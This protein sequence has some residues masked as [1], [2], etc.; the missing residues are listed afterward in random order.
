MN[1]FYN[2]F[3]STP[4]Q[5]KANAI[6]A[7][8][9]EE[10]FNFIF[11]YETGETHF[12]ANATNFCIENARDIK[13]Y[14]CSKLKGNNIKKD[15]Y[16]AI[17]LFYRNNQRVIYKL[18]NYFST[19]GN[20]ITLDV[21][22]CAWGAKKENVI[23]AVPSYNKENYKKSI[24][25]PENKNKPRQESKAF[26]TK[27]I[28]YNKIFIS[29][30]SKDAKVVNYF[31]SYVLGLG[32]KIDL[33]EEVYNTSLDG[34]NPR[35]GEDFR[36]SIKEH[37]TNS[38]LVLQF[39]SPNYKESEVCLNEMGAAWV[40][41]KNVIPLIVNKGGYDVGFINSTTQQ[42]KLYDAQSITK[43][44]TDCATLLTNKPINA[45]VLSHN[46]AEFIKHSIQYFDENYPKMTKI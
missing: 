9:E 8:T 38:R 5:A 34:S 27:E 7:L 24:S 23:T 19:I 43:F 14:D 46:I 13:V 40:L 29:H 17:D 44:V 1:K 30:S 6:F 37:L 11:H 3:Y 36:N 45:A 26:V 16:N 2:L 33:E 20:D 4:F 18:E 22:K 42:T 28:L 15:M 10:F 39:I 31:C 32:L 12:F 41:N 35:T 25:L 21:I